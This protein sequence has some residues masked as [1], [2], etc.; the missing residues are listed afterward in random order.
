MVSY[1]IGRVQ[2]GNH[3]SLLK[4]KSLTT[5]ITLP[6]VPSTP[7][8]PFSGRA[9]SIV[10]PLRKRPRDRSWL[11]MYKD[12][13]FKLSDSMVSSDQVRILGQNANLSMRLNCLSKALCISC[14]R[15]GDFGAIATIRCFGCRVNNASRCQG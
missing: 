6:I 1:A 2:K 8:S 7:P 14:T 11:L 5:L 4:I 3:T 15:F 13:V 9:N 12:A 10:W